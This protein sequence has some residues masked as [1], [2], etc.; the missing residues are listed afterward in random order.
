M[1]AQSNEVYCPS[2]SAK[3]YNRVLL[4]KANELLQDQ[5]AQ[6]RA[7]EKQLPL[8]LQTG[9]DADAISTEGES[10]SYVGKLTAVL[11][12]REYQRLIERKYTVGLSPQDEISLRDLVN[13]LSTLDESFY[14]PLIDGLERMARKRERQ[15]NRTE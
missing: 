4:L 14:R 10:S 8:E 2:P 5:I 6:F 13:E 12:E 3:S 9:M 7:L 1:A 15:P 11:R